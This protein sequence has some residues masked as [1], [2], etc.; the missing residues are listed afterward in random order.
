MKRLILVYGPNGVGKSTACALLAQMLPGCAYVDSDWCRAFHPFSF[1]GDGIRLI[2]ANI[3]SLL[4]NSLASPLIQDVL[5]SYGFHG[6]RRKIFED[7][8]LELN[9]SG[10]PFALCPILLTCDP[11]ENL[12]RMRLDGRDG[13]RIGRAMR[14]R[15]VYEQETAP[16][17]DATWLTPHQTAQAMLEILRQ[18]YGAIK[19]EA[20]GQGPE[21]V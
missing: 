6:P 2:R 14:A 9:R 21:F 4:S 8:L 19:E 11:E 20:Y 3:A 15:A 5:F 10:V 12:R 17:V 16:R 18:S 1:R 13:E 7:V